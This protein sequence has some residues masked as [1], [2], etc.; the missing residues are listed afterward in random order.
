[1]IMKVECKLQA[2]VLM[3]EAM[4]ASELISETI[5]RHQ[6]APNR[7]CATACSALPRQPAVSRS[8]GSRV[9]CG[10]RAA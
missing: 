9:G 10:N 8:L 1:M 2:A 5:G 4:G 3:P 6:A 7:D